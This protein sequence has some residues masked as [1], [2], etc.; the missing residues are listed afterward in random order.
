MESPGQR[1]FSFPPGGRMKPQ[2]ALRFFQSFLLISASVLIS[3]AS[4]NRGSLRGT[5]NDP[6]GAA[7]QNAR[8]GITN[9]DTGVEQ[10]TVTN[11]A[12]FYL[13]PELVPGKYRVHVV[14]PGFAPM[15][16][17]DVEVKANEV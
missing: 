13:V 1:R 16:F 5:V 3:P 2:V 11:G 17:T 6:Q 14:A 15:D 9:A 7:I 10:P 8:V 12:G 4:I